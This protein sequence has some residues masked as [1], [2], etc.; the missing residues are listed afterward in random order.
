MTADKEVNLQNMQK[1]FDL[2]MK[3]KETLYE[4]APNKAYM[5][6]EEYK[7][8][9]SDKM[10]EKIS[11]IKFYLERIFSDFGMNGYESHLNN[12]ISSYKQEIAE[13]G[14]DSRK[15]EAFYKNC[16]SDMSPEIV[17][18]TAAACRGHVLASADD[19]R[20]V[21]F[22][23][24]T[25][26]ELLHVVH[27]QILNNNYIYEQMPLIMETTACNLED[28]KL[29]GIDSNM[30]QRAL[31]ALS[32]SIGV[33]M[34][35]VLGISEGH[36]I[37][38]IRDKGHALMIEMDKQDNDSIN[39]KYHIPKICNID[40]IKALH[41]ISHINESLNYAKGSFDVSEK[42]FGVELLSF[43][44]NVP[45]DGNMQGGWLGTQ[46]FELAEIFQKM[47]FPHF[48]DFVQ[49]NPVLY[50]KFQVDKYIQQKYE[51]ELYIAHKE[52]NEAIENGESLSKIEKLSFKI[53][54][55]YSAAE[56]AGLSIN[57]PTLDLD[58]MQK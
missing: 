41:G 33:G 2:D 5:A 37:A 11:D 21:A 39:V 45:E 10:Y 55:I 49:N 6:D 1:F 7:I 43:V 16:L 57:G 12:L 47:D 58:V 44:S 9:L 22:K 48:V 13:A 23:T 26:N 29:Y 17:E 14:T 51:Y 3:I 56:K 4:L 53:K 15:L 54:D 32:S 19:A 24:K 30:A 18:Q 40:M 36:V 20:E 25:I 38:M 31:Q 28:C 42:D 52:Q 50:E 34:V 8:K 35:D 46:H 27:S